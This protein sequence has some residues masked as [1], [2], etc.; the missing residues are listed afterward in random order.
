MGIPS[1]LM[2]SVP[3]I[4]PSLSPLISV[5]SSVRKEWLSV[6]MVTFVKAFALKKNSFYWMIEYYPM[7]SPFVRVSS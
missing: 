4:I 1:S 6:R 5:F 7:M 2:S 3:N